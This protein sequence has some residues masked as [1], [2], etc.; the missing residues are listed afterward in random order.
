[1]CSCV[2]QPFSTTMSSSQRVTQNEVN[3]LRTRPRMSVMANPRTG[4][5]PT[6]NRISAVM[7]VVR[8][9][10]RMTRKARS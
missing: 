5:V 9:V 1:M 8:W 2:S 10:S 3:K 4:P 6:P 7:I